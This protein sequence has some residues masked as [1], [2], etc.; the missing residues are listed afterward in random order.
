MLTEPRLILHYRVVTAAGDQFLCAAEP[1]YGDTSVTLEGFHV[2]DA[3]WHGAQ[4]KRIAL[5]A[6]MVRYVETGE[7]EALGP[8]PRFEPPVSTQ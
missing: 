6:L 7:W 5:P 4:P 1:L 2:T 8:F 3:G